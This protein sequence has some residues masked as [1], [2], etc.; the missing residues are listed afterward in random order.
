MNDSSIPRIPWEEVKISDRI[1]VGASGIVSKGVW[2]HYSKSGE[3]ITQDIATKELLYGHEIEIDP[4]VL[5][6]FLKE[7]KLMRFEI[8]HPSYHQ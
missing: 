8:S 1:G 6:E 2:E 5:D 4:Q 7:V 3:L